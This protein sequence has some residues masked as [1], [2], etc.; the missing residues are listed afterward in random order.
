MYILTSVHLER[1]QKL[2]VFKSV[3]VH[4]FRAC[5]SNCWNQ[6]L[7]E[8]TYFLTLLHSERPKLYTILAFLSA[9]GLNN[10]TVTH[11]CPIE[12]SVHSVVNPGDFLVTYIQVFDTIHR[13]F[14]T[15]H[16]V[17]DTVHRVFDTVHRVFAQSF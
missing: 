10:S 1:K 4:C 2:F 14:D 9:I 13:V 17:F 7:L 5:Q 8:R 3:R 16:R 11:R 15:V 6:F 12:N